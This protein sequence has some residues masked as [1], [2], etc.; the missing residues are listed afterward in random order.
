MRYIDLF[1]GIGSFHQS[2]DKLGWECVM[3]C[4]IDASARKTYAYNHGLEPLQDIRDIYPSTVPPFDI[5]CAG[6]P[7]QPF[8]QAGHRHGFDDDRGNLFFEIM[9][10]V[11][12]HRPRVVILENVLGLQ[13]HDGGNTFTRIKQ[14]LADANYTLTFKVL[15]CSDFGIPQM[16]KRLFIIAV[17]NE[18]PLVAHVDKLLDLDQYKTRVSLSQYMNKDFAKETAYTIRCGGRRSGLNDKHNWDG[19]LVD[20]VEYRLTVADCLKLQGFPDDF[21]LFGDE[22]KLLGNTIPT[23]FT[24]LI[25]QQIAKFTEPEAR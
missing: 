8:S 15:K 7:C 21:K 5:V 1:C 3:A 11:V 12:H 10:L 4:D 22:W 25:G 14:E 20:G 16:R 13:S 23:N 6:F 18:D 24:T 9:K 17:K 2:F 19:Y